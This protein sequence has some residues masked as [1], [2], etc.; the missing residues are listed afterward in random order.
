MKPITFSVLALVLLL[1]LAA[2]GQS[3]QADSQPGASDNMA[4]AIKDAGEK[5]S[6]SGISGEIHK[7][8]QDAK[9]ELATKNIEVNSV[10]INDNHHNDKD[11]RPK[12]EITPQGDLLIAGKK[13]AATPAQ[14][15]LLMDY[16]QQIVGIAETGMDIGAQGA[17]LGLNAAK[18]GVWGA[19]TGKSDK[20]IEAAIKPQTD[21]I[22]AAAARLCLRMP[23]LL[24]TQQKLAAAM[25]EFRPYATMQQKDVDDCG[26]D[27]K[28]KDGSFGSRP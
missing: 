9:Q 6:P 25:P 12:A 16:R 1:P 14:Q 18:E 19:L 23:D 17:D 4:Q 27:M 13:V 28:D 24:S 5:T 21:K 20:D 2:C 26:K 3:K 11:S 22:E 7:A 10:H 15:T 8:M